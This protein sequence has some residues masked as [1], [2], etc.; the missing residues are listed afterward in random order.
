MKPSMRPRWFSPLAALALAGLTLTAC[1][2]AQSQAGDGVASVS[3]GSAAPSAAASAS[4]PV[5]R[6]EAA[7]K[8]AQCMR[9]NGVEVPDPGPDGGI[10]ITNR[11]GDGAKTEKALKE[12]EPLT[13]GAVGN[14]SGPVDQK[15]HDQLVKYAQCMR[16]N[17][18]D[19]PDPKPGGPIQL[20]IPRDQE[21]KAKKAM[22]ACK[23]LAP[24]LGG[25][26]Q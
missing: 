23:D 12:C 3:T 7:L 4:A 15:R 18:V 21:G 11:S 20:R 17:G 14:G 5:D 2:G 6:R 22:E 24:G 19:M 9:E 16:E 1:G 10:R 13:K 8:F 26:G 25:P